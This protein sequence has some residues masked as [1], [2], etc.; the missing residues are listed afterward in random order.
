MQLLVIG[1]T[2]L[3]VLVIY[4]Q[5]E[6]QRFKRTHRDIICFI[7]QVDHCA[8]GLQFKCCLSI[9]ENQL[10]QVV[11]ILHINTNTKHS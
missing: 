2:V 1:V 11:V 8:V 4:M 7:V 9:N 3:H 10:N 6:M 5:L